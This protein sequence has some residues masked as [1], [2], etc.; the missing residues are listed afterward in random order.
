MLKLAAKEEALE[1]ERD[2]RAEMRLSLA[3]VEQRVAEGSSWVADMLSTICEAQQE[4]LVLRGGLVECEERVKKERTNMELQRE[5]LQV[6]LAEAEE[7]LVCQAERTA[8]EREEERA[9]ST[10]ELE[11]ALLDTEEAQRRLAS[12][13]EASVGVVETELK[14]ACAE[15]YVKT[16]KEQ[17]VTAELKVQNSIFAA[18]SIQCTYACIH[19]SIR[20]CWCFPFVFFGLFKCYEYCSEPCRAQGAAL[21][22][23]V[24]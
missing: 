24:R 13:E 20:C 21:G 2:S 3:A 16:L 19:A 17:L 15:H 1:D 5:K 9:V 6:K 14:L 8:H 4:L 23:A 11:H 18:R 10:R 7:A 22:S 12:L